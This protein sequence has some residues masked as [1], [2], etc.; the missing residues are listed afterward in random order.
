MFLTYH[1]FLTDQNILRKDIFYVILSD[2]V[3]KNEIF[4]I[5]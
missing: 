1:Y 2:Y 4:G 5:I 3:I